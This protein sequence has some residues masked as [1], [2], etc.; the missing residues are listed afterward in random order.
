MCY[1]QD[2]PRLV[3]PKQNSIFTFAVPLYSSPPPGTANGTPPDAYALDPDGAASRGIVL[4]EPHLM[5]TLYANQFRFRASERAGRKFKA[6]E[7]IEL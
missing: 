7:S 5:F 1:Y 3:L 4:D 2:S 6:K